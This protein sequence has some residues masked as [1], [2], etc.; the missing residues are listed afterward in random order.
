MA[1]NRAFTKIP[2][3]TM[4]PKNPAKITF[5]RFKNISRKRVGLNDRHRSSAYSNVSSLVPAAHEI[6]SAVPLVH[7]QLPESA[8][9]ERIDTAR[10]RWLLA[11]RPDY[12]C[13][14]IES[15]KIFSR[16][17][18][19]SQSPQRF[20]ALPRTSSQSSRAPGF[21]HGLAITIRLVPPDRP[22][23]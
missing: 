9:I 1:K 4:V 20:D 19:A 8:L 2:S 13:A 22:R 17:L 12:R 3:A 14:P 10:R 11:A 15:C 16:L 23:A 7:D 6:Q 21:R 18:I 5:L